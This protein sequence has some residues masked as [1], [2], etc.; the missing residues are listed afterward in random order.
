MD[1]PTRLELRRQEEEEGPLIRSIGDCKKHNIH[2]V[3]IGY[4]VANYDDN[5]NGLEVADIEK[6]GGLKLLAAAYKEK[7]N[8]KA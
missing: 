4:P 2:V 7:S 3:F 5:F 1:G 6:F 8:K